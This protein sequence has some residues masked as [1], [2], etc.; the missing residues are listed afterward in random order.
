VGTSLAAAEI[1]PS[2][3]QKLCNGTL[4]MNVSTVGT[5]IT[6]QWSRNS[7]PIIGATNVT[8]TAVSPGVYTVRISNG[9]CS[10][11]LNTTT[12]T[13]GIDAV[14]TFTSPNI[15]ST[16]TFATYQWFLDGAVIPGA[17]TSLITAT[18]R[19]SYTVRVTDSTGCADTANA[20]IYN[21]S[22]GGTGVGTISV[23]DI[24][25]Y[26]NPAS[27]YIRVEAPIKVNVRI[28]S[29]DGKVVVTQNDANSINIS[30]LANGMYMIMIYDEENL[31]LKT[32]KFAKSE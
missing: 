2:G 32:V 31:L 28:L 3:T 7:T 16:G 24:H 14:I 9:I 21:G 15:L 5:G 20:Y 11:A 22:G 27:S 13:P 19:G 4:T 18:T 29:V 6:Y 10:R 25:V 30:G 12:V 23:S 8:Y 26:P 1:M 17:N